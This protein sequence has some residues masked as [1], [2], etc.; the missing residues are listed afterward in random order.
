VALLLERGVLDERWIAA[1]LNELTTEDLRLL[2][3]A[4]KFHIAHCPRSHA[5]FGHSE[6]PLRELRA[7]GF[8]ICLGTDSL[9]SNADLNLLEEMRRL[10]HVAR[11][12][13][14]EAILEMA[15]TRA[16]AALNAG[17]ALGRI[18]PGFLADL[19]AIP[20]PSQKENEFESV[21]NHTGEVGWRML[22]GR[23][24]LTR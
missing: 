3:Q 4:P 14:P 13:A 20:M 2:E 23:L 5:F 11:Y 12:L 19:I 1:H 15:T 7:R 16:A 17:D 18:R 10:A 21:L 22:D 6:F 24:D 9:A 8:N